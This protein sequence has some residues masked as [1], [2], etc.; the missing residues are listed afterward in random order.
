MIAFVRIA[1]WSVF[2]PS[3][4]RQCFAR[5]YPVSHRAPNCSLSLCITIF[6]S[7]LVIS[8]LR[9]REPSAVP[10]ARLGWLLIV[11]AV[12]GAQLCIS[13]GASEQ[14]APDLPT[15]GVDILPGSSGLDGGYQLGDAALIAAF[16]IARKFI[17]YLNPLNWLSR[18]FGSDESLPPD[19]FC[20]PKAH[21]GTSCSVLFDH[22]VVGCGAAGCPLA[23]TLSE[24]GKTVCVFG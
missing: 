1:S 5:W 2:V 15:V 4:V 14:S 23:R 24:G 13:Q 11:A 6:K 20:N 18:V 22:V 21:L 9:G 10:R 3:Q 16:R 17:S 19:S 8:M 12:W 7:N